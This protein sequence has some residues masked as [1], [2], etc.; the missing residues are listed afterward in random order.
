MAAKKQPMTYAELDAAMTQVLETLRS[1]SPV[2]VTALHPSPKLVVSQAHAK[3]WVNEFTKELEGM[4]DKMRKSQTVFAPN[5]GENREGPPTAEEP[6]KEEAPAK[7]ARKPRQQ[8]PAKE[9]PVATETPKEDAPAAAKGGKRARARK[10][11]TP[12]A[13]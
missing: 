1:L 5:E 2:I 4:R 12:V 10:E 3:G 11:K 8:A 9:A 6:A 7:Q 13:A